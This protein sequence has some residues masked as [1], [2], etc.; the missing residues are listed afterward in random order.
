MQIAIEHPTGTIDV[1]LSLDLS[2][3]PPEVKSAGILRTTRLLFQGAVLVPEG[4][5]EGTLEG[6][7]A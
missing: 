6:T 1:A 2:Q 7:V 4:T 5:V 3:T